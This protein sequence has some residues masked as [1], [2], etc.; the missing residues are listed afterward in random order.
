MRSKTSSLLRVIKNENNLEKIMIA[1]KDIF[2]GKKVD[3]DFN[4]CSNEDADRWAKMA[5]LML[6]YNSDT[7]TSRYSN[8]LLH[9]DHIYADKSS[10]WDNFDEDHKESKLNCIGNLTLLPAIYN[11]IASNIK[12]ID[13][14]Q[15]YDCSFDKEKY[16]K[17]SGDKHT[18]SETINI[19][20]Y[21]QNDVFNMEQRHL[22]IIEK[23]KNILNNNK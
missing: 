3:E 11:I 4:R 1:M 18:F 21:N 19:K 5:L 14:I 2:N 6:H 16:K 22:D 10:D 13:K 17:L 23:I 20:K 9:L 8:N 15:F 12:F 7:S